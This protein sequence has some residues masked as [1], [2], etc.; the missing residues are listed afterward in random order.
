MK[1]SILLAALFALAPLGAS[2]SNRLS[3]SQ[4]GT[5]DSGYSVTIAA[6]RKAA[7]LSENSI[8]GPQKVADLSCEA[9]EDDDSSEGAAES[10]QK[11]LQCSDG[12]KVFSFA[13]HVGGINHLMVGWLTNAKQP[14]AK[15][16]SLPCRN[17]L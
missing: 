11:V 6:D 2:A 10:L 5:A 16:V 15:P 7:E 14:K 12:N 3:C 17:A 8:A 4:Q 9:V 13:L 1:T